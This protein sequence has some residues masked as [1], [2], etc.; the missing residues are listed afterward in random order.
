[1][2]CGHAQH[3]RPDYKSPFLHSSHKLAL[4]CPG[5]QEDLFDNQW[6]RSTLENNETKVKLKLTLIITS[7]HHID[8]K[9]ILR[10]TFVV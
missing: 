7:T 3:C 5:A 9:V 2:P 8:I 10:F 4:A 6:R 1:V